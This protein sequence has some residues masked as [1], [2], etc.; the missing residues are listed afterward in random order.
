MCYFDTKN[1]VIMKNHT[2]RF[3]LRLPKKL[4]D[5]IDNKRKKSTSF[6]SRN[7]FIIDII[8]NFLLV[9]EDDLLELVYWARRYCDGRSTYAPTRF[10][11]IYQKIRSENPDLIRCKDQFDKTLKDKGAYWPY[12]Q[13]GQYDSKTGS[14][15]ARRM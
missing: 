10:N 9:D 5:K 14:F 15:D 6:I 2:I 12:A 4:V 13:D 1:G 8:N 3:T 7:K 11:W